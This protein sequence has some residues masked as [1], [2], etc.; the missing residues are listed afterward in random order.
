MRIRAAVEHN[1]MGYLIY[2]ENLPGAFTR[3]RTREE[4]LD[5]LPDEVKRYLLWATGAV[6]EGMTADIQVVQEEKSSLDIHQADSEIIFD[7]EKTPLSEEEYRKMIW[8]SSLPGISG[9]CTIPF[10]NLTGRPFP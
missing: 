7:S 4:A 1:E 10:R 2:A 6:P 9:C 3:G 8:P 5:K